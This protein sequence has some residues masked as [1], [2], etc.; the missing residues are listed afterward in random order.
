MGQN[1]VEP[2][3]E[4]PTDETLISSWGESQA[5]VLS[6]GS[7]QFWFYSCLAQQEPFCWMVNMWISGP[8]GVELSWPPCIIWDLGLLRS[9]TMTHLSGTGQGLKTPSD[10]NCCLP[11]FALSQPCASPPWDLL[12]GELIS[13]ASCQPVYHLSSSPF[14]CPSLSSSHLSS[15]PSNIDRE[16]MHVSGRLWIG[17]E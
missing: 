6:Q 10:D 17:I 1:D 4:G 2:L 8:R 12:I 5:Y 11:C 7:V 16:A 15:F 14:L 13:V 3:V 9:V